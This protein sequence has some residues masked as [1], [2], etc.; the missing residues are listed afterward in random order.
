MSI[1]SPVLIVSFFLVTACTDSSP[2][3]SYIT[4]QDITEIMDNVEEALLNKDVEEVVKYMSPSVEIF[5]TRDTLMGPRTEKWSRE[6]YRAETATALSMVS[7][8]EYRRENETISINDDMQ[9]A[10]VETD[11]IEVMDLFGNRISTT[12]SE[13]VVMEIIDGHLLV[14]RMDATVK[15][16]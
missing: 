4:E 6:K 2:T 12:T 7:H 11:V 8:Y 10:V 14:T 5:V 13:R 3:Y 9:S 1:I 15:G 16:I